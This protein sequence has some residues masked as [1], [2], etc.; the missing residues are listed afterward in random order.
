L[1][2]AQSAPYRLHVI[3]S[4]IPSLAV[5]AGVPQGWRTY[6][7]DV[8]GLSRFGASARGE[9]VMEKLGFNVQNVTSRAHEL[10]TRRKAG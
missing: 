9:V 6:V 5:E 2:D 8:I 10:I 7:D 3:P 4:D 1:F